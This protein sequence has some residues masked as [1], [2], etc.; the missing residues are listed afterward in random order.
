MKMKTKIIGGLALVGFIYGT[1]KLFV[2]TAH[3]MSIDGWIIGISLLV[4]LIIN[5][6]RPSDT[7]DIKKPE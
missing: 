5:W 1:A 6:F 3:W 4:A 7:P 2:F